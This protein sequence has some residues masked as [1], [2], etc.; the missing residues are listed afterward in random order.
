MDTEVTLSIHILLGTFPSA[1][2]TLIA[3][4]TQEML[5]YAAVISYYKYKQ[6]H[7]VTTS[8]HLCLMLHYHQTRKLDRILV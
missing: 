5:T 1:S 8:F 7:Q 2:L 3:I 4:K 6:I